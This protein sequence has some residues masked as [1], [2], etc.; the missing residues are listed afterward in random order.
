M[1][2][3]TEYLIRVKFVFYA[4]E[5]MGRVTTESSKITYLT[6]T[7]NAGRVNKSGKWF[8]PLIKNIADI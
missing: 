2:K 7:P 6:A 4:C 8:L 5:G 3:I 1:V